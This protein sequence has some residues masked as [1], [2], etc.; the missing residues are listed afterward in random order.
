MSN[1]TKSHIPA[2]NDFLHRAK[3]LEA[4][5]DVDDD[6]IVRHIKSFIKK[7]RSQEIPLEKSKESILQSYISTI[8][9]AISSPIKPVINATGIILHTNL[10][11]APIDQ[12]VFQQISQEALSYT[13]IE[14]DL[15]LSKRM[16]RDDHLK[17]IFHLVTGSE[18]VVVVN[19]NA[20]SLYL[21]C[22]ALAHKKEIIIS[23]G[24]L[25]EIGGSFRIPDMIRDAGAKLIE[26]GTTNCTKISDYE[27]AI[28]PRTALILKAHQS[29][30]SIIGHTESVSI[31]S[32]VALAKKYQLPFVYDAGSGL[33]KKPRLLATIDEPVISECIDKGVDIVCFSGDKLLGASQAGIILG[34]DRLLKP[35]KKHPLMRVLRADKITFHS[36]F[37]SVSMFCSEK[38][39]LTH[40]K[41]FSLLSQSIDDVL[42][43]ASL[44]SKCLTGYQIPHTVIPALAQIG[45]GSLPNHTLSSFEIQIE[46]KNAKKL[47][48]DLLS[49]EMPLL[50]ILRERKLYINVFCLAENQ[51]DYIARSIK[52]H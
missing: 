26:V 30:F 4:L 10:G 8:K 7:I 22:K 43:K 23:R 15:V 34:S 14:F 41:V 17:N 13:N 16:Y 49:C 9:N 28:S 42:K 50:T 45:G 35:L 39:L 36:L 24:E 29:N 51:M 18:D 1:D 47:H 6:I 37:H 32:L 52:N 38:K 44:L 21:I 27:V 48:Q 11:R 33:L 12:S 40:N 19:N 3:A 20:A 2:V 5:R 46:T 25:I 31:D